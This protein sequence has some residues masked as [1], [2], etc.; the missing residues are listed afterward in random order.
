MSWNSAG[1]SR[2]VLYGSDFGED[3]LYIC[4]DRLGINTTSAR[5][6]NRTGDPPGASDHLVNTL[7]TPPEMSEVTSSNAPAMPRPPGA[8]R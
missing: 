4:H 5:R 7:L 8:A 6:P 2:L 1:A 3:T